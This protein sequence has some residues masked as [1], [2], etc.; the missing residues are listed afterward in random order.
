MEDIAALK[1]VPLFGGM[2]DSQMSGL[3]ALMKSNHFVPGQTIIREGEPGDYFHVIV[4]GT[5]QYIT[6]DATGNELILD[7]AGEGAFFG[8]L[9]MITGEPRAIRVRAKDQ[10]NTLALDRKDFYEFLRTRPDAAIDMLK[11]LGQRLSTTDK[12]LRQSVSKNVNEIMEDKQTI[13]QRISD[14]FAT[15]M[16]S[17]T[18]I[19]LMTFFLIAWMVLNIL[20]WVRHW[21]ESPFVL[22]NLVLAF[23]AAYAAPIIMMSQNRASEKDRLVAELDHEVN[24]RAEVKT[25]LIMNRLDDIERSMHFLHAEQ[26]TMLKKLR[27]TM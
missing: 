15:V 16:G 2:N 24:V 9:S 22:L 25:G 4:A 1:S 3:R 10:V 14:G 8:E 21:D 27:E 26:A 18:F 19:I 5:V 6:S 13:G 23:L 17:W 11:V 20:R 12:L 7:T